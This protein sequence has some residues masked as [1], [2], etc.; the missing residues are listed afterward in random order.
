MG[1][2]KPNDQYFQRHDRAFVITA[3]VLW[4]LKT[5]LLRSL[6]EPFPIGAGR[7]LRRSAVASEQ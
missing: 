4:A 5:N 2:V 7:D 1:I 3:W 6:L